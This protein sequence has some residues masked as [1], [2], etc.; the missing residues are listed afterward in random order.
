MWTVLPSIRHWRGDM[1]R[2]W[3]P[4]YIGQGMSWTE[5]N[6]A[7][8]AKQDLERRGIACHVYLLNK[9]ESM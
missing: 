2:N 8:V 9:E 6:Q 1:R 3:Q 7:R 4:Y 5:Y